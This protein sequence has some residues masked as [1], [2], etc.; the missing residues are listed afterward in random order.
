MRTYL[1]RFVN[2]ETEQALIDLASSYCDTYWSD[3]TMRL[4]I[5]IRKNREI[6]MIYAE[7]Y[8]R[9]NQLISRRYMTPTMWVGQVNMFADKALECLCTARFYL[10]LA[11]IPCP[12]T[13]VINKIQYQNFLIASF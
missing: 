13:E 8:G 9:T 1:A 12:I 2:R 7:K 5:F 4:K 10:K 3:S 6:G 11:G